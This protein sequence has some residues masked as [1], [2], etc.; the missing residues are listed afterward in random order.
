ML[1]ASLVLQEGDETSQIPYYALH[2]ERTTDPRGKEQ[3]GE[4]AGTRGTLKQLNN[5][6]YDM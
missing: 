6:N 2:E 3:Y 1:S 5:L 4:V